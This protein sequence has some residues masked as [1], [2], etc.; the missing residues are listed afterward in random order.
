MLRGLRMKK[1]GVLVAPAFSVSVFNRT[2]DHS[3]RWI[4]STS[5]HSITSPT[6]RSW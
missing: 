5:K 2:D 6:W 4:S 3:V 1:A